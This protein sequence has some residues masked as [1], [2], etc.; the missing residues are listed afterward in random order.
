MQTECTIRVNTYECDPYGHV[1]NATYLN[2]LEHAR[3]E[4]LRDIGFDYK[5]F[6][7]KGFAVYI[8]KI[9]IEY[10][11][12]AW[13]DDEIIIRTRPLKKGAVS[14]VLSQ[15]LRR[16]SDNTWIAQAQVTWAC[17]NAHTGKPCRLPQGFDL[18]GLK[19]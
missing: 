13:P 9:T 11:A 12:S 18:E 17:V 4:F 10:K 6:V 14:G 3:Y 19:P 1:N 5:D 7:E 8:A 16:V 15:E 2:Y